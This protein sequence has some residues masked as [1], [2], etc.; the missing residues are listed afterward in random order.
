MGAENT[1]SKRQ[2]KE[3]RAVRTSAALCAAARSASVVVG[4]AEAGSA[5][6]RSD[7]ER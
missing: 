2:A 5:V 6:T 7:S 1:D 4:V 3:K